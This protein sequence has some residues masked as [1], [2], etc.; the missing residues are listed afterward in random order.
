VT[1]YNGKTLLAI[2]VHYLDGKFHTSLTVSPDGGSWRSLGMLE[3]YSKKEKVIKHIDGAAPYLSVFPSGE[4]YLT[5]NKDG[6]LCARLV[7]PDGQ[8]LNP[9][10]FL[11]APAA[12]SCWGASENVGSHK[13]LSVFP[14]K[15]DGNGRGIFV[16]TSYLK[17][18]INA[19][20]YAD[21]RWNEKTDALF[22]GSESQA[23]MTVQAAHDKENVY[24]LVNRLDNDL[25]DGD[26][27]TLNIG[28]AKY[29]NYRVT[30]GLDGT[31]SACC[32]ENGVRTE[33]PACGKVDVKLFGTVNDAS[34]TD[35]GAVYEITLPRE[36]FEMKGKSFKLRPELENKDAEAVITDTLN[37]VSLDDT[38]SWPAVELD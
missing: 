4:A 30:V 17:H 33:M 25:T 13:V 7:S 11:A 6:K 24:F 22:V 1:L 36:A 5:Y 38:D 20:N 8:T 28:V 21:Y 15:G 29:K 19:K 10:E 27:V 14:H 12:T 16:Y 26:T 23:Q 18:R 34:D 31:L 37:G 3:D 35:D 9:Y 32:V 2:E